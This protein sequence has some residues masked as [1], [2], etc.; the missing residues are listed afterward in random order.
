GS[1]AA[2]GHLV[3]ELGGA[4]PAS[5]MVD[6]ARLCESVIEVLQ[7]L[8]QWGPIVIVM[9]DLHWADPSTQTLF[10]L[11]AR[12]SRPT[13]LL[14][15]GTYRSDL[16]R[17]HPLRPVLAEVVRAARPEQVDLERF[18]RDRTAELVSAIAPGAIG[19]AS[20]DEIHR[21]SEGNAFFIEEL[22]AANLVGVMGCP[23]SLRDVI[24]ARTATLPESAIDLL[25]IV[26]VAGRSS[27]TVLAM[28][29]G[30]DSVALATAVD[31]LVTG[32]LLV[33]E[34]DEV[35]FT[36]ELARTVFAS[37]F[38]PETL[39]EIHGDLARSIAAVRPGRLGEI[40]RH[41]SAAQCLRPALVSWLAAGRVAMAD[42][43][44]SEAEGHFGRGL[45]LWNVVDDAE[46]LVGTDH[47]AVLVDA[48]AAAYHAR[49]LERAIELAGHAVDE[50]AGRDPWREG[51]VWLRLRAMY[52]FSSRWDECAWALEHALAVI[53]TSPPSAARVEALADAALG[54][55]YAKRAK[56][57]LACAEEALAVASSLGDADA[58]VLARN[59]FSAAL[60]IA[61]PTGQSALEQARATVAMCGPDVSPEHTLI[62]YNG[63][64]NSLALAGRYAEII[65]VAAAGVELVQSSGLGGPLGTAMASYWLGSLMTLGRWSEAEEL[66]HELAGLLA[67]A[68]ERDLFL[69]MEIALIRQGRLDEVRQTMERV[70]ALLGQSDFWLENLCELGAVLVEFDHA[71]DWRVDPTALVDDL[72]D[73]CRSGV[74]FGEWQ[75]L[76]SG[77]AALA[78]RVE[79]A[80]RG[81]PGNVTTSMA[82]ANCW[83]D[84]VASRAER[85]GPEESLERQR[86]LAELSRLQRSPDPA[87]WSNVADGWEELGMR[88][89]EAYARWRGAEARLAGVG[90]RSSTARCA[91]AE[92]LRRARA[93][94]IDLPATPLMQEI[95]SLAR[96]AGLNLS[97]TAM[98]SEQQAP[99]SDE[100]GLTRRERD[101]LELVACGLSNGAIGER[102]FISRKT[103]SVHV[104]NILRKLSLDNRI[105][106]AAVLHRLQAHASN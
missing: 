92:L 54:H 47:A 85:L 83:I 99:Q 16:P 67:E 62:A 27:P 39:T 34:G 12:S 70:R 71:D 43:A 10:S 20:I 24:L 104:S 66:S 59:A 48:A 55:G 33:V 77:I 23:K 86:A 19:G 42:G 89:E 80:D 53:P 11:L 30:I 18:D 38:A 81:R 46:S 63:L 49:H 2:L 21:L 35:R 79:S 14:L 4:R 31:E 9:E 95:E 7:R 57:A 103:A 41:W 15:I 45:E 93:L 64:T 25:R 105:E 84:R 26:A 60:T 98:A 97:R 96:R 61:D 5:A 13:S 87:A 51:D 100:L 37:E 36:H 28:A 58:I 76:G 3:P 69:Y 52:R 94:A 22:V 17:R 74:S 101:V 102:L 6:R 72:L 29:A 73:R 75:L 91:A 106:A 40:A 32:G 56:E 44:P 65:D 1:R 90:G 78:D 82:I 68:S 88:Y 50:L 8:G